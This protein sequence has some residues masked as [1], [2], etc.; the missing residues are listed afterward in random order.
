MEKPAFTMVNLFDV[1]V[2]LVIMI[3]VVE[4]CYVRW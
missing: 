4:E 1:R 3:V 2:T